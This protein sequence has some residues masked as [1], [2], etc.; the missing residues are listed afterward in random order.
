MDGAGNVYVADFWND[1][2]RKIDVAGIITHVG[3][4]GLAG[5]SAAVESQLYSPTAVAADT[6]G[7]VHCRLARLPLEQGRRRDGHDLDTWAE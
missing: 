4:R 5:G 2:V 1:P 7:P 6:E 3:G